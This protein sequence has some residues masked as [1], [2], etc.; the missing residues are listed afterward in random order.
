MSLSTYLV[1]F[2]WVFSLFFLVSPAKSLSTLSFQKVCSVSLI[3]SYCFPIFHL[4]YFCCNL[5]YLFPS[6]CFVR[7]ACLLE[8]QSSHSCSEGE[9]AGVSAPAVS[10]SSVLRWYWALKN[11]DSLIGL[12]LRRDKKGEVAELDALFQNRLFLLLVARF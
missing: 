12:L 3:F 11:L 2:I 10:L 8:V 1:L 5:C 6:T 4:I 9:R 7:L